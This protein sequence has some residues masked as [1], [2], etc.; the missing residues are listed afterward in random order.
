MELSRPYGTKF[1]F[2]TDI[3]GSEGV[4]AEVDRPFADRVHLPQSAPLEEPEGATSTELFYQPSLGLG[5]MGQSTD[6]AFEVFTHFPLLLIHHH[7]R[8]ERCRRC[9]RPVHGAGHWRRHGLSG[10]H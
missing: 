8:Y 5:L 10:L 4:F 9:H 3:L 2:Q 7:S 6:L 1:P